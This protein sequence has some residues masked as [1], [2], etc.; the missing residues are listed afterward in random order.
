MTTSSPDFINNSF[1]QPNH[2]AALKQLHAFLPN[3]GS[4]YAQ[5]RNFDLDSSSATHV[6]LLSPWLRHRII[7]EETV[8]HEVLAQHEY[9]SAEKFIQEVFWRGYFKGWLEQRPDVW[10]RYWQA[11]KRLKLQLDEDESLAQ[12]YQTA[13]V[14]ET[15]IDCFD[16][17]SLQ[18]SKT[19]YLHNHAR[20]WFASIWIFTLQLPW[21]LGADF[22]YRHLLDG[23]PAS[24]TCSWRWVAGLHT[25]GKTYLA[26]AENIAKYSNG[27]FN[28]AGQLAQEAV[29]LTEP[30][31]APLVPIDFPENEQSFQRAGLLI[32]EEDCSPQDLKVPNTIVSLL[33][34]NAITQRSVLAE[35]K[36]VHEFAS[37]AVSEAVDQAGLQLAVEANVSASQNWQL[38]LIEWV[39][40]NSLEAIY[41]ARLPVGPVRTRLFEALRSVNIQLIEVTREYD[42][43][44]WP[45]ASAGFFKLKKQIPD[46]L[47]AL[48]LL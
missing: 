24:N 28:P 15:G 44:C 45:H 20:M 34:L 35:T 13:I 5:Q 1:W 36:N 12:R 29:A 11:T 22:F 7:T 40:K 10:Q 39:E 14:G 8:L 27:R 47:S 25:K 43:L 21:E 32:T 26:T 6:S 37:A 41:T 17:W 16:A 18:L 30:E 31:Q 19:G 9:H 33:G 4:V 3:A 38:T 46:I 48:N 23:D 42:R 2:A